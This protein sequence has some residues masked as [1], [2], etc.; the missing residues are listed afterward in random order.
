MFTVEVVV[1]DKRARSLAKRNLLQERLESP[2]SCGADLQV[3]H[4]ARK[5]PSCVVRDMLLPVTSLK[6]VNHALRHNGSTRS[7][8]ST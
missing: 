1:L 4:P 3:R 8:K 5:L 6:P 2:A 7:K